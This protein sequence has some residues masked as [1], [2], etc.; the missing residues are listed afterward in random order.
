LA[1]DRGE[2][3]AAAPVVMATVVEMPPNSLGV[4]VGT[5]G[6]SMVD[7]S[8]M[9]APVGHVNM[10][11]VLSHMADL[12]LSVDVFVGRVIM[13][14]ASTIDYGAMASRIDL[15]EEMPTQYMYFKNRLSPITV[16]TDQFKIQ[17]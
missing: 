3:Q 4:A 5:L 11:Q 6:T 9:T 17:T 12:Q 15:F 14:E 2:P 8:G 16:L 13:V 7:E 1:F 10:A